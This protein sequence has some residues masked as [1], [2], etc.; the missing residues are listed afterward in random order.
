MAHQI[1]IID[2]DPTFRQ[3]MRDLLIDAGH[4]VL[5]AEDGRRGI[6]IYESRTPELVITDLVMPEQEG[7]QTIQ[8]LADAPLQPKIIAI[9]GG[10]DTLQG[11]LGNTEHWLEI[12]AEFGADVTMKKPIS[13]DDF[14]A[15]VA[16]VLK[17]EKVARK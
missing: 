4:D 12:A 17:G 15:T 7:L 10:I 2:D 3:F 14:V 1:L 6:E 16:A 5:E 13:P 9:S 11:H 8:M